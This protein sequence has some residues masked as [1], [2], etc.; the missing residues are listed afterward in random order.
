MPRIS[1]TYSRASWGLPQ[2]VCS[3]TC[4]RFCPLLRPDALAQTRECWATVPPVSEG[5]GADIVV[6]ARGAARTCRAISRPRSVRSAPT[7][8]S[9]ARSAPISDLQN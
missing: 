7:S 9:S 5:N 4:R 2:G 8:W 6:T 1:S 3:G